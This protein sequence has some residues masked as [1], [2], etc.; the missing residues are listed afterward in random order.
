MFRAFS[1]TLLHQVDDLFE[2]N[3]KLRY[4]KVNELQLGKDL[5]G[6]DHGLT[7]ELARNSCGTN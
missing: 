6:S 7:V 5:E 1:H 4:Q 3:V 2:L